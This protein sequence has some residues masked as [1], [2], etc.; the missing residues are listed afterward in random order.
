MLTDA[1]VAGTPSLMSQ[2]MGDRLLDR[3]TFAQRGP[4]A[5]DPEFGTQRVLERIFPPKPKC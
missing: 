4:A 1:L 3:G 5:F 2:L